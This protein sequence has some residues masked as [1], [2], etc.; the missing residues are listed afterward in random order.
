VKTRRRPFVF[1][2]LAGAAASLSLYGS[3]CADERSPSL[4]APLEAATP[5]PPISGGTLL[6][7]K[8]SQSAVFADPDRNK[9]WIADLATRSLRHVIA[10]EAGDEPGRVIE[11]AEGRVFVALRRGGAVVTIDPNEGKILDRRDACPAP[12]GMAYDEKN[13][14]I[15]VAC[16]GGELVTF[17]ESSGSPTRRLKLERDLRDIVVDGDRLLITRFRS[18]EV[19]DVNASGATIERATLPKAELDKDSDPETP[20]EVFEPFVAWR[21]V[22]SPMGGVMIVHQR[23]TTRVIKVTEDPGGGGYGGPRGPHGCDGENQP[24]VHGAITSLVPGA[25][26]KLAADPTRS[27]ALFRAALPVDVALSPSGALFASVSAGSKLVYSGTP[28]TLFPSPPSDCVAPNNST[29][30]PGQPISVAFRG[31]NDIVVGM[32]EPA[33]LFFPNDGGTLL[34]DAD[35]Q[36]DVGHNLFHFAPSGAGSSFACASCHPEGQHDARTWNFSNSGPRRTQ[37]LGGGIL[38][39]APL[40]WDGNLNSMTN[41]MSEVFAKRMGGAMPGPL[42]REKL[43]HW[44]DSIPTTP[45][46][47]AADASAV[48]RGEALF[49]DA[50]VACASCHSGAKYTDNRSVDVGTGKA[51]QV[52][53]L[54]GLADRA[55]YMHDGCAPTLKDRFGAC[56]G[57]DAH[58]KTSHLTEAQIDDLVAYLE[59]L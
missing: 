48:A 17:P 32:R 6:V 2:A 33:G 56:G 55:P 49:H 21:M 27:G 24:V 30:A 59:T 16:A 12:R 8:D 28:D 38:A 46:S 14:S 39:T 29:V 50:T 13:Q 26:G 5:P 11:G 42:P 20:S 22:Q 7:T 4:E 52:P 51:L 9:V 57:G 43:E 19:L 31:E 40:H 54:M 58:G 41:L 23:A 10:L 3:G 37:S 25:D 1:L 53:Q 18:A 35:T 45:R 44:V 36:L 47:R 34:F 15:H